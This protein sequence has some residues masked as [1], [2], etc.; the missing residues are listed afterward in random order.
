MFLKYRIVFSALLFVFFSCSHPNQFPQKISEKVAADNVVL[1]RSFLPVG[2]T[3]FND[4]V[5]KSDFGKELE[6]LFQEKKKFDDQNSTFNLSEL[7]NLWSGL[8]KQNENFNTENVKQ[9]IE[10][11]G[12]LLEITGNTKYAAE[13]E[14][15]IYQ[16][17][18]LFDESEYREIEKDVTPWIFTKDLD[19]IYINLFANATIKYEHSMK[20]AV[21]ITQ[22]SNYPES[23]NIQIKFKMEKKRYI[24]LFIRIPEWAQGA[25]V[26]EWKVKYVTI[27]GSYTQILR[28]WDDGDFVEIK[29]PADL[30]P[31]RI[32]RN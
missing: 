27:P 13:L 8:Q 4:S 12:F 16:S 24:E 6:K 28:K 21:E 25:T 19:Q 11:T 23:G 9:W 29:L 32:G 2:Y 18:Y 5:A 1:N 7:E 20:G 26:T 3:A 14:E 17:A 31:K 30:I 15:T 10:I 22:E